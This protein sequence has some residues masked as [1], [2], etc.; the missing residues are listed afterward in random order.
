MQTIVVVAIVIAVGIFIGIIATADY[1][2]FVKERELRNLELSYY[3]LQ[4]K[5]KQ[6]EELFGYSQ[7][8]CYIEL[9][10]FEESHKKMIQRYEGFT[11]LEVY[12]MAKDGK[13]SLIQNNEFWD[14]YEEQIQNCR[15]TWLGNEEGLNLCIQQVH[16]DLDIE[17]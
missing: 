17:N 16:V 14:S 1:G 13:N 12:R 8:T 9:K 4:Q 5:I 10:R 7:E 2:D 11:G 6:C 3:E 15:E